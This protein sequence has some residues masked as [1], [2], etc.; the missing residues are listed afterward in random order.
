MAGA[1]LTTT[2]MLFGAL[3]V[4]GAVSGPLNNY[5]LVLFWWELHIGALFLGLRI[6]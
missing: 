6:M 4:E 2:V 5:P 1:S 3:L